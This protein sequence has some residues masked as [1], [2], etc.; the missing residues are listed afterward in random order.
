MFKYKFIFIIFGL[1]AF[2]LSLQNAQ[3]NPSTLQEE[4]DYFLKYGRVSP[5][6]YSRGIKDP[7]PLAEG[8]DSYT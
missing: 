6:F 2:T 7:P 1:I 3:A 5:N 4:F 8:W